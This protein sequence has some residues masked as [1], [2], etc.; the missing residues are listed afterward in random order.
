M[1]KWENIQTKTELEFV[2]SCLIELIKDKNIKRIFSTGF[3]SPEK[4]GGEIVYELQSEPLYILF[5]DNNCL[6][7][8]YYFY[9][10][11]Y[12]EYR[13]LNDEELKMS[14]DPSSGLKKDHFN[15]HHEIYGW[16]CDEEGRK[17]DESF[18]VKKAVDIKG[19]YSPITGFKVEG[20]HHGY[21]KW[22]SNGKTSSIVDIPAGGDYFKDVTIILENGIEIDIC[23]ED[24]WAD[25]YYDLFIRD[26]NG[27]LCFKQ[28]EF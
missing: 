23:P 15:S 3:S 18:R 14:I 2:L 11:F 27:L 25:G 16:D 26:S 1:Y 13:P 10:V 17:I 22:I 8:D 21:E 19:T 6:I 5:E 9:S 4:R 12:I 20:F 24:A 28:T 7:I